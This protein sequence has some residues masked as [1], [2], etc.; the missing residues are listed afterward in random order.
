MFLIPFTLVNYVA[1][2]ASV[3][4]F[5]QSLSSSEKS[6]AEI[7]AIVAKG[8]YAC[9]YLMSA[10][11]SLI[12]ALEEWTEVSGLTCRVLE[13]SNEM[14][15]LIDKNNS[16]Y[17]Q[18]FQPC[19]KCEKSEKNS[20]YEIDMSS[21]LCRSQSQPGWDVSLAD[22][23]CP[24]GSPYVDY[25]L[26][27]ESNPKCQYSF[28]KWWKSICSALTGV[29]SLPTEV[30]ARCERKSDLSRPLIRVQQGSTTTAVLV[31]TSVC[32]A[33]P[34]LCQESTL[35]N[36]AS[37]TEYGRAQSTAVDCAEILMRPPCSDNLLVSLSDVV[38]VKPLSGCSFDA[39][40]FVGPLSITV[41]SGMRLLITGP[42]GIGKTSL[43]RVLSG[44]WPMETPRHISAKKPSIAFHCSLDSIMFLPQTPYIFDVRS[45]NINNR[46]PAIFLLFIISIIIPIYFSFSSY[47]DTIMVMKYKYCNYYIF[48]LFAIICDTIKF[49]MFSLC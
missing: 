47:Y 31:G 8:S 23:L 11:T 14:S 40:L 29:L 38:V 35:V 44:L 39:S 4:Y 17:L 46:F 12:D 49:E 26:N 43:F 10:F 42:S 7:A 3:L 15:T 6:P 20:A 22:L 32:D 21:K 18:R 27:R 37:E 48:T 25:Y 19:Q 24:V 1:V 9:L 30:D 36:P 5:H 33:T 34:S 16:R 28:R 41:K 45:S 2:G 13:L